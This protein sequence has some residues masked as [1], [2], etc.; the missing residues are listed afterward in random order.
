LYVLGLSDFFTYGRGVRYEDSY[1][2]RLQFMLNQE[3]NRVAVKNCAVR[4]AGLEEVLNIYARESASLPSGSLVING[5]VPNDFGLDTAGSIKGLNFID[6]N[7]GGHTFNPIRY[8]SAL[9][10]F[11]FDV[12]ETRRLY[13]AAVEAYFAGFENE[14]V[15]RKFKGLKKFCDKMANSDY[16]FL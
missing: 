14:G 9:I 12:I 3:G 10:D 1:S 16:F 15:E 13:T 4:G 8:Q 2:T 7:N 11:A 6:F 5:F